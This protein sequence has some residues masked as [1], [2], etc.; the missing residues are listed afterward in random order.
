MTLYV[1]DT[2]VVSY[3]FRGAPEFAPFKPRLVGNQAFVSFMT[4]AELDYWGESR[5]WGEARRRQL[6]TYVDRHF[7]V[8][9]ATRRLCRLWSEV[10]AEGRRQGRVINTADAWIAATAIQLAAPLMTRNRKD[11]EFLSHLTLA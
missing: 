9:P 10:T 3:G 11:F 6:Q 1:V 5:N 8:Y 2:D 4:V 7:G